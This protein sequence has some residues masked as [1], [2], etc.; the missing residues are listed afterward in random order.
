MGLIKSQ[1]SKLRRVFQNNRL[2]K[3]PWLDKIRTCVSGKP[4]EL[5]PESVEDL[6]KK[7]EK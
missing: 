7:E 1:H 3:A 4:F 5:I 2:P 6:D